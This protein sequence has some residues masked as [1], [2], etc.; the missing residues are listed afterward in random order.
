MYQQGLTK[1]AIVNMAEYNY[2]H[3]SALHIYDVH[4]TTDIKH[5]ISSVVELNY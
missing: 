1:L 4:H 5:G 3:M 2:I